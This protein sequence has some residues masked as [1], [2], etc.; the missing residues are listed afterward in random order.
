MVDE[1]TSRD[2]LRPS[3]VL[4]QVCF[5]E[6]ENIQPRS[7]RSLK[8][9]SDLAFTSEGANGRTYCVARPKEL[10]D[11]MKGQEARAACN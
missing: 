8:G 9:F 3:S 2:G 11:A 5:Y 7:T 10:V 4:H 6:A 1:P